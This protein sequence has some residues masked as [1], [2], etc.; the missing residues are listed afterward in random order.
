MKIIDDFLPSD[1][2]KELQSII[3]ED[4]FPWYYKDSIVHDDDGKF[5]FTHTF[6]NVYPPWNGQASEIYPLLEP[7]LNKLGATNLQ[8]IKANLN[9]KTLFHRKTGWHTDNY[10]CNTT[11]LLYFNTN[12]GWTE[13]KKGGKVKSV[14]NRMVIFDSNLEHTGVTCTNENRRVMINFNYDGFPL[15]LFEQF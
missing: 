9:V 4:L 2:F 6:Y 10:D 8:R 15:E 13:F 12:N 1:Q 5:G 14:E 7:C 3:L 11:A